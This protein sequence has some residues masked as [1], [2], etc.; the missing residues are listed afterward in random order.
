VTPIKILASCLAAIMLLPVLVISAVAGGM[1]AHDSPPSVP[2]LSGDYGDLVSAVLSN[3][4]IGFTPNA[5]ADVAAGRIDSRV[6]QILLVLSESHELAPVGPLITGHSYFV[7]GTTRVSNHVF[8]RAVDIL[9][10]DGA[11]VSRW[12]AGARRVIEEALSLAPPLGPDEVGGPWI[13]TIGS[14]SSFTN[15]DH[16]DHIHIGFDHDA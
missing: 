10:V 8:G 11:P 5:R 16:Q 14:R 12:N 4:N 6:L 13:V 2:T 3:H 7:K 9:G 15:P 1:G